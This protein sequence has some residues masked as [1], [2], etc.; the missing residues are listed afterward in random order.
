MSIKTVDVQCQHCQATEHYKIGHDD[1]EDSIEKAVEKLQ[2]KTQIQV[3]S[4]IR[5]HQ[6]DNAEY[7]F[8]LFACPD[9]RILYNP[10]SVRVEYDNIM[11]FQ[12]FHKCQ[13]CNTT[14]IKAGEDIESY[15]CRQCGETQLRS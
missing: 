13:R 5:K 9:C 4:I 12:P 7:G 2:G 8:A 3:R 11:V 6:L 14:L 15:A 10:Y 1:S